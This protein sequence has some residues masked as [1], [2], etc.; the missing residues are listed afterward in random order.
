LRHK[1]A[2]EITYE[3]VSHLTADITSKVGRGT[4]TVNG[5]LRVNGSLLLQSTL[6][7]SAGKNLEK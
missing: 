4:R 5:N 2:H 3:L 7:K 6:Q 1:F